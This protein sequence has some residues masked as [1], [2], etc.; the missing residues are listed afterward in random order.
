[1]DA[2]LAAGAMQ[3]QASE[4]DLCSCVMSIYPQDERV[5]AVREALNM[6]ETFKPVLMVAFG[7]PGV[8]SVSGASVQNWKDEQVHFN[9]YQAAYTPDADALAAAQ[10]G[11]D[12]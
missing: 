5:S 4:M 3:V 8:D 10:A 2:G 6:P 11:D 7:M 9:A 12:D 1:M